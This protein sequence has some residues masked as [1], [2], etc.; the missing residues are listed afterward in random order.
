V[1]TPRV[2]EW[3][4]YRSVEIEVVDFRPGPDAELA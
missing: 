2:N 3:Q 1:F 4:G